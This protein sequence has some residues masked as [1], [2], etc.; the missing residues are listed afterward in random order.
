MNESNFNEKTEELLREAVKAFLDLLLGKILERMRVILK[1]VGI[2][3]VNLNTGRVRFYKTD[4]IF[5][6]DFEVNDAFTLFQLQKQFDNFPEPQ[7][8]QQL[9]LYSQFEPEKGREIRNE[10]WAVPREIEI[11]IRKTSITFDLF[12]TFIMRYIHF[13]TKCEYIERHGNFK[14]EL[15]LPT[16][17]LIFVEDSFQERLDELKNFLQLEET[18]WIQIAP[19]ENIQFEKEGTETTF[20]NGMK[21]RPITKDELIH[22]GTQRDPRMRPEGIPTPISYV[23]EIKYKQSKNAGYNSEINLLFKAFQSC[24]RVFKGGNCGVGDPM[25][26][27]IG[28]GSVPFQSSGRSIKRRINDPLMVKTGEITNLIDF[29]DKYSQVIDE[30]SKNIALQRF[31]KSLEEKFFPDKIIDLAISLEAIALPPTIEGE[32]R[33]RLAVFIANILATSE[34]GAKEIY[35]NI[36]DFYNLR[37][38][39]VHGGSEKS[40]RYN[41]LVE[42]IKDR[43]HEDLKLFLIYIEQ[44]VRDLLKRFIFMDVNK[45]SWDELLLKKTIQGSND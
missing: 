7:K 30:L 23:L 4:R 42:R 27:Q 13:R 22:F 24:L 21:I 28:W 14:K 29:W 41:R 3:D 6:W 17:V 34:E 9:N 40:K 44:I 37:S 35:D 33:F 16:S 12:Q 18:E 43:G 1:T 32:L 25:T 36:R 26:K 10:A 5:N 38:I 2:Y 31:E 8:S 19:L 11:M 39:Y 20:N 45:E 15:L